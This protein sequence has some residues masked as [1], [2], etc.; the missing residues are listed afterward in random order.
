MGPNGRLRSF[1]K[2]PFYFLRVFLF[3]MILSP[4]VTASGVS[5]L[6]LGFL[7]ILFAVAVKRR[8]A[9]CR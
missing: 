6:I 1:L 5:A 9:N 3:W 4:A 2:D 7:C 8:C